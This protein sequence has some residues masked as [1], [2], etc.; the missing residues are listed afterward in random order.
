MGLVQEQ[1]S[2]KLRVRGTV[3]TLTSGLSEPLTSEPQPEVYPP[4]LQIRGWGG[5]RPDFTNNSG[6]HK[7][8]RSR[9]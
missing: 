1:G 2:C 4:H 9:N 7:D 5:S 6:F 3:C 8:Q